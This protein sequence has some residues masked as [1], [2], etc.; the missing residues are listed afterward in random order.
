MRARWTAAGIP[1]PALV[2]DLDVLEAN[3]AAMA[4]HAAA[5]HLSLRP[6]AKTHKTPAVAHRQLTA[7][8]AGLAVATLGE[9]E[10]FAAHGVDD[11]FVAYPLW[12]AHDLGRRAAALAGHVR[13]AVG[14]DSVEA[15]QLLRRAVGDDAEITV[16]VEVDCGLRRSG[17]PPAEAATVALAAR[18]AGLLVGGVFTFPGHSYAPGAAAGARCDEERALGVAAASLEAAGIECPTRSGG[19]T[20]TARGTAGGVV[21][22]LRPGVYVFNDAQQVALGT[23]TL[24]DVAL[25]ALAT[26][27]STP[28]PGRIVLDSGSKVL[29]PERPAWTP[30]HGLLADHP[31]APV[32][33]LW[34]HHAVVDVSG[35]ARSER[36]RAGERVA[37][38]PNHVC[39]AVNLA[40]VLH[41]VAGGDVVERWPVAAA[42]ANR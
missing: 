2:V 38:V 28:A 6:H 35:L 36:P 40:Q 1:T 9:A 10:V 16:L 19:S 26:V 14:A 32:T 23:C 25:A 27:V 33:G 8:A 20:P 30:G 39:T 17:V 5:E 31:E 24:D 41:V 13:L 29:G 34:E 3:V 22:E 4:R 42:G 21:T 12:A 11:L 15:I 18:D 7:G 37:V